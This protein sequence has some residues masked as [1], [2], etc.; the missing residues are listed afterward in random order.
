MQIFLDSGDVEQIK[1]HAFFLD[2]VTTNPT[3]LSKVENPVK[4][5]SEIVQIIN[6]PVS[7][8]VVSTNFTDM[9]A[10][11][12][13]IAKI[14]DNIVVKL[15]VTYDGFRVLRECTNRSIKTNM[16]LCFSET[17]A[18]FAAKNSA[19]FVSP[20]IGRLDDIGIDGLNLIANIHSIFNN[21][22]F[23]TKILAAS[24][25]SLNHVVA[26]AEIGVD[27]ITVSPKILSQMIRHPLTEA[28]LQIFMRDWENGKHNRS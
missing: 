10:E 25:R 22:S 5:I 26:C 16:T 18:I 23:K 27:A 19:T 14:A 9:L 6:G 2:G 15:P 17:Q 12:E 28:G 8:E 4:T 11:A 13:K 1:E 20:F 7:V 3:L 24:V 21:Y